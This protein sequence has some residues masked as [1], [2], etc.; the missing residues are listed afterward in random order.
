MKNTFK[1]FS[2]LILL[3]AVYACN[4]KRNVVS[5]DATNVNR[6]AAATVSDSTAT[7]T[8]TL[9]E[10]PAVRRASDD[11]NLLRRPSNAQMERAPDKY[12][13]PARK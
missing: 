8:D 10:K 9:K 11:K 5:E 2:I 3:Q 7:N 4:S 13:P 6:S 1:I 12:I